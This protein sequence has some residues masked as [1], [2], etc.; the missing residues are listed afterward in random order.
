MH[1]EWVLHDRHEARRRGW[2]ATWHAVM[3]IHALWFLAV[4]AVLMLV[5]VFV[6]AVRARYP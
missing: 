3:P 2:P 1:V 4:L 5:P 6:P